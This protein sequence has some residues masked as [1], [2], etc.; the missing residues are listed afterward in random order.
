MVEEY[1]DTDRRLFL[2]EEL[3]IDAKDWKKLPGAIDENDRPC[4]TDG[5]YVVWPRID[6]DSANAAIF[7]ENW[8][9]NNTQADLGDGW[10]CILNP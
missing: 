5:V 10:I 4:L 8:A 3:W 6:A 2:Q 1:A 9:T 7:S